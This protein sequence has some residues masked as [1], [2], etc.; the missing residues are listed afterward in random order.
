MEGEVLRM[1]DERRDLSEGKQ[2]IETSPFIS[3]MERRKLTE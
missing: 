1:S 3:S 2:E